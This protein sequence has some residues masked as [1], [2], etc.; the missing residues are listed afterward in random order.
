MLGNRVTHRRPVGRRQRRA[1]KDVGR[2]DDK[3]TM[4]SPRLHEKEVRAGLR[5]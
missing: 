4:V 2:L 3:W 5:R 1:L